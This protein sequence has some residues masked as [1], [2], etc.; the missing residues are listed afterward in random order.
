MRRRAW[1]PLKNDVY[2]SMFNQKQSYIEWLKQRWFDRAGHGRPAYR[3]RGDVVNDQ[4]GQEATEWYR[5]ERLNEGVILQEHGD[6]EHPGKIQIR[7]HMSS[8]RHNQHG[9]HCL[10]KE[11]EK[12]T[13]SSLSPIFQFPARAPHCP[14]WAER[15]LFQDWERQPTG[16]SLQGFQAE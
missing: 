3:H 14:N 2:P 12:K 5:A 1:K 10:E 9:G 8:K 7:E 16:V 4:W 13:G 15:Q 11:K 6:Q